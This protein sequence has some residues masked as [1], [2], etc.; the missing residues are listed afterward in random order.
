ML[1]V[2][3]VVP[4]TGWH[5]PAAKVQQHLFLESQ[6]SLSHCATTVEGGCGQEMWTCVSFHPLGSWN[7]G[8][9]LSMEM[10]SLLVWQQP[11]WHKLPF[12][13]FCI[14]LIRAVSGSG[15]GSGRCSC[16]PVLH[17]CLKLVDQKLVSPNAQHCLLGILKMVTVLPKLQEGVL[18]LYFPNYY[19]FHSCI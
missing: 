8:I 1:H 4:A 6:S 11:N 18:A 5:F 9:N 14:G 15:S 19:S 12:S 16:G 13:M 3:Y 2:D 7:Q 17:Q 10:W